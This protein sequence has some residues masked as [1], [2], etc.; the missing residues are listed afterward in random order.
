[1]DGLRRVE[2]NIVVSVVFGWGPEELEISR[3][4][5]EGWSPGWS[6]CLDLWGQ[7]RGGAVIQVGVDQNGSSGG[8]E[9][10]MEALIVP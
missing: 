1:M 9:G 3:D 10:Q 7:Q 2:Q 8:S 6:L 4:V 5:I